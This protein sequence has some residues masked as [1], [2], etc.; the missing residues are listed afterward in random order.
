MDLL[1]SLDYLTLGK[2]PARFGGARH[3]ECAARQ[4]ESL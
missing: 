3:V 4:S 1:K 2:W